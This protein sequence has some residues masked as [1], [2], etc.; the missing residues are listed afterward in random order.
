M[1]FRSKFVSQNKQGFSIDT[2]N[3]WKSYGKEICD[4][5]LSDSRIV[6]NG[7]INKK[8]IDTKL[9]TKDIDVRIVNK[10]YGIL[11]FEIWYRLFIT[12]EFKPSSKLV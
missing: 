6:K 9:K 2:V 11:A 3:L 8:W 4:Y 12:K 7:W 10:F 5:Y 1:L